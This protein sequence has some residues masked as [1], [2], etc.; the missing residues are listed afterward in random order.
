MIPYLS[1]LEHFMAIFYA[2][3]ISIQSY[4]MTFSVLL[5]A[6]EVLKYLAER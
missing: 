5:I 3:P 1:A 6:V 2:L 4:I